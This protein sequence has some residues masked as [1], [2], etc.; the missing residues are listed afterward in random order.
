[1]KSIKASVL[2]LMVVVLSV[3]CVKTTIKQNSYE[4]ALVGK[5]AYT[6]DLKKTVANFKTDG[7]AY[8]EGKKYTYSSDGAFISL[9]NS[10]DEALN[11]RYVQNEDKMYVYIQSTYTRETAENADG[12]VGVWYCEDKKWTF[13]F[14]D[15]GTFMEDGALTGYYMVDEDAGTVKLMYGEALE[16]TVFYYKLSENELHVEYPWLMKRIK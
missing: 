10:S 14:T 11:L 16:D 8:F 1:M 9:E 15:K 5:W 4:Q 3:G 13:E 6:H 7:N 12:I 2:T